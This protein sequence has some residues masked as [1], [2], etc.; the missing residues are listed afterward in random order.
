MKLHFKIK[1]ICDEF[2]ESYEWIEGDES[3]FVRLSNRFV[4][5]VKERLAKCPLEYQ[6][7][8]RVGDNTILWFRSAEENEPVYDFDDEEDE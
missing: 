2:A 4:D 6:D 7:A 3:L 8:Q 5:V 1:M